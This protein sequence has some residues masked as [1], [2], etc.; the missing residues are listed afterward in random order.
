M[1][2]TIGYFPGVW[3]LLHVGHLTALQ[4]AKS[5]CDRLFVGVPSDE[6]VVA[7][8]GRPPVIPADDRERM[9]RSLKVVDVTLQYQK[10]DF[11]QHLKLVDPDVLFV[12]ETWGADD[13]HL[14]AEE[15]VRE[16]G[17]QLICLP[18]YQGE[19]TTKIKAR[20]LAEGST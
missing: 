17:K 4:S 11:I 13:R 12:G 20:I 15:W 8:K 14:R 2:V 18:Y 5:L 1:A 9:L 6:V 3:D 19:S 16:R 7:D 10:L